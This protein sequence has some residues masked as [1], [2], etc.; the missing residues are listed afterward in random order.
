M[1]KE[2]EQ[3]ERAPFEVDESSFDFLDVNAESDTP[4]E[5]S[6]SSIESV[7]ITDAEGEKVEESETESPE[8]ETETQEETEKVEEVEEVEKP[9]TEEESEETELDG[10]YVVKRGDKVL[11]FKDAPKEFRKAFDEET[12]IRQ[13]FIRDRVEDVQTKLRAL[14]PS[15]YANLEQAIVQ[16]SAE[17]NADKW[18]EYLVQ[19]NKETVKTALLGAEL[20]DV[21]LDV[22]S[23]LCRIYGEESD[24]GEELRLMLEVRNPEFAGGVKP[25]L[26]PAE[27]AELEAYRK[28]EKEASQTDV[29]KETA[30]VFNEI[31]DYVDEQAVVPKLKEFGLAPEP[32]DTPEELR[33]KKRIVNSL[34]SILMSELETDSD[35]KDDFGAVMK[36]IEARDKS[37]AMALLPSILDKAEE[38][39]VS[40]LGYIKA[41]QTASLVKKHTPAKKPP[42]TLAA[43]GNTL[44]PVSKPLPL[45]EWLEQASDDDILR[46]MGVS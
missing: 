24:E 39:V 10:K 29:S 38:I 13:S 16:R 25:K 14:S 27:L 36:K 30:Q 11:Y 33:E 4:P 34:A 40:H 17:T 15:S 28:K 43:A 8:V 2:M 1:S 5:E 7:E 20:K 46:G 9:P 37:G 31:F 35:T 18:A 19:T 23:E 12:E 22:I 42:K 45:G 26:P 3:E 6:S 44:P 41:Q 21:N 32:N